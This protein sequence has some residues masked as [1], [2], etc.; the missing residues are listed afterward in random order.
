MI[1][2][3]IKGILV[4][5]SAGVQNQIVG[6][7][8]EI[9]ERIEVNDFLP[10]RIDAAGWYNKRIGWV[11]QGS[12]KGVGVSSQWI[13]DHIATLRKIA[14]VHGQR[15]NRIDCRH[16]LTEASSLVVSEDEG[17]IL[18][19]GSTQIETKLIPAEWSLFGTEKV[20]CIQLV[21]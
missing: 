4:V 17:A 19:D 21:I 10:G 16:T 8:G 3:N 11:N 6:N 18:S 5:S 1:H 7:S 20:P 15:W 12:S 13:I 2:S 9:G 14:V